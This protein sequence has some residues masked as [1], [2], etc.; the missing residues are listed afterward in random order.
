MDKS[1]CE[2]CGAPFDQTPGKREKKFCKD[3]CRVSH[4]QKQKRLKSKIT[5]ATSTE[6]A[7][8]GSLHRAVMDEVGA[9]GDAFDNVKKMIKKKPVKTVKTAKKKIYSKPVEK[10]LATDKHGAIK[11]IKEAIQKMEASKQDVSNYLEKRR[12]QKLG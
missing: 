8:D 9:M 12:K 7:F 3:S 10:E 2:N 11:V 5:Y 6:V 4:C 1:K